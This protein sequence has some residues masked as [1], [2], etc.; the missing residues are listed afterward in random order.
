MKQREKL[1]NIMLASFMAVGMSFF[2]NTTAHANDLSTTAQIQDINSCVD[3]TRCSLDKAS[4]MI[5]AIARLEALGYNRVAPN[6]FVISA[7]QYEDARD[8][9]LGVFYYPKRDFML[10]ASVS[11]FY[12]NE[13]ISGG[14]G[15]TWK[16]KH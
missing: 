5:S 1:A 15:A 10:S 3:G 6:E 7:S 8:L 14:I 13:V 12:N 9:V 16:L 4:V 2:A 11:T